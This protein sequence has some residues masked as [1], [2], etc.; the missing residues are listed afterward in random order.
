MKTKKILAW[1]LSTLMAVQCVPMQVLAEG[2]DEDELAVEKV[3]QV[4]VDST[5]GSYD[6]QEFGVMK[7]VEEEA[8]TLTATVTS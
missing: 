5:V 4:T 6:V 8:V 7:A 2:T 1:L 3:N